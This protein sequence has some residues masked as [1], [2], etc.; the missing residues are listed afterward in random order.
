MLYSLPAFV[1]A[2]YLQ[3][4]FYVKLD[5]LPLYGMTSDNY[6]TLTTAGKVVRLCCSTRRCR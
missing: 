5:W 3:L 4:L 6:A 1:A 2:L